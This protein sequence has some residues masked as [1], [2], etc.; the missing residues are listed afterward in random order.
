MSTIKH[1]SEFDQRLKDARSSVIEHGV[2]SVSPTLPKSDDESWDKDK[3]NLVVLGQLNAQKGLE[4]FMNLFPAMSELVNITLLGC[5]ELPTQLAGNEDLNVIDRYDNSD[6]GK[7]MEEIAPDLG[8]LLSIWPE[9][10]SYTLKELWQFGVPVICTDLGAFAERVEDG[11][12]GWLVPPEP[13]SI[14]QKLKE[15]DSD[16]ENIISV[17]KNIL[18]IK[19]KTVDE[20]VKDYQDH[21][22]DHTLD[23]GHMK[24]RSYDR[25]RDQPWE[26]TAPQ[27][28]NILSYLDMIEEYVYLKLNYSGKF[29]RFFRIAGTGAMKIV[30]RSIRLAYRFYESI[31]SRNS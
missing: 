8:M 11:V 19:H 10:Y 17:Q 22:G 1:L 7:F 20:M 3:L 23:Y 28:L 18:N 9:T 16:R 27:V 2:E 30:S 25:R 5:G 4:L 15:L 24:W 12:T 29:N 21:F 14:I 26:P 31:F 13:E 6:L